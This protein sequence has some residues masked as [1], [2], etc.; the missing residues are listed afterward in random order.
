LD[1]PSELTRQCP[2]N[3]VNIRAKVLIEELAEAR[4]IVNATNDPAN[5]TPSFQP[6]KCGIDSRTASEVQEVAWRERPSSTCPT[7]SICDRIFNRLAHIE[8]PLSA[9]RN[10]IYFL[11]KQEISNGNSMT[12]RQIRVFGSAIFAGISSRP[13]SRALRKHWPLL[14]PALGLQ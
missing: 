1:A 10:T 8:S 13:T 6:V 11:Q 2:R 5:L 14:P 3:L 12:Q 9:R 4:V 7:D